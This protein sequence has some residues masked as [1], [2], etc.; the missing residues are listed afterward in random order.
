MTREEINALRVSSEA[1]FNHEQ[2]AYWLHDRIVERIPQPQT[3]FSND[4]LMI[5]RCHLENQLYEY[6]NRSDKESK[7]IINKINQIL[8]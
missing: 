2:F 4:E 5:I 7:S 8:K 6:P 3:L 1:P